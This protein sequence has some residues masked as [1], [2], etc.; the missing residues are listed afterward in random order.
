[1]PAP[2]QADQLRQLALGIVWNAEA[3]LE[4]YVP[5]PN[6]DALAALRGDLG[7]GAAPLLLYGGRGSGKT[8]LLQAACRDLAADG[9]SYVPLASA[10]DLSPELLQG[11]EML[12]LVALDDLQAVAGDRLWEEAI[13]HLFN[14]LQA[15]GGRLLMAGRESPAHL[16]LLLPDLVS[17]LQWGLVY[18][19]QPLA[20]ADLLLALQ[21]RARQRGLEL[22]HETAQYLLRRV[23]RDSHTLFGLLDVLDRAALAAQR[24]LTVPFVRQ[25]LDV[26]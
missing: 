23:P 22:P 8:H 10:R 13:F 11:L 25:V 4:Q 2:S 21:R 20:E 12:P 18:R 24:R 17:R 1:M 5:G 16:P 14:R 9:S 3:T 7:D 15:H 19:L 26:S 6:A